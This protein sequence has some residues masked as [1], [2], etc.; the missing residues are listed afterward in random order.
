MWGY[1]ERQRV[2]FKEAARILGVKEPAIRKRV[3]RGT[4]DSERE[5]NRVY[6]YLDAGVTLG[7]PEASPRNVPQERTRWSRSCAARTNKYAKRTAARITS[8]PDLSSASRRL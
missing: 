3:K 8:S 7:S 4:L 6:L 2:M 5:G 1:M